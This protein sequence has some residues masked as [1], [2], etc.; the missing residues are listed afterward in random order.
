MSDYPKVSIH[1]P[2]D[3]DSLSPNV[4]REFDWY[5]VIGLGLVNY[6]IPFDYKTISIYRFQFL[7]L[8]IYIPC[9]M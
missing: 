5:M 3:C 8:Y 6:M 4:F 7:S 1:P 9:S 2:P